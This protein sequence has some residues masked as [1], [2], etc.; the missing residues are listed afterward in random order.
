M[1]QR[2]RDASKVIDA[3]LAELILDG[4]NRDRLL[5]PSFIF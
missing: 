2:L 4:L 1:R 3:S 5:K